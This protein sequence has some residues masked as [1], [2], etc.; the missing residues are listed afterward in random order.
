LC[1]YAIKPVHTVLESQPAI[2]AFTLMTRQNV[3]GVA[4][5]SD[6]GALQGALSVRDLKA[7][8]PDATLFWR[9]Y[10]PTGTFIGKLNSE[11]GDKR[12]KH[13]Q[14]CTADDTIGVALTRLVENKIHRV[15]IVDD[16]SQPI[17][18]FSIKDLLLE[19]ISP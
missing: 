14:Y 5:L 16:R 17:G 11:Y 1:P 19:I 7:A 18:V 15:F 12:P 13:P 8:A 2:D 9:L 6:T 10:Q 3:S 4:V